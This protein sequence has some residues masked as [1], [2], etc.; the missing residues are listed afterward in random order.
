MQA[1]V[2]PGLHLRR[3]LDRFMMLKCHDVTHRIAAS[4]I[5]RASACS[6]LAGLGHPHEPPNE[7][8]LRAEQNS[9]RPEPREPALF[10]QLLFDSRI[11]SWHTIHTNIYHICLMSAIRFACYVRALGATVA[12]VR[13]PSPYRPAA[14][15]MAALRSCSPACVR[16]CACVCTCVCVRVRVSRYAG[17]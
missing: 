15:P 7:T 8:P 14:P 4:P 17:I 2:R 13:Q 3:K 12:N 5:A 9:K 16:A 11:N 6:R 10:A 1:D